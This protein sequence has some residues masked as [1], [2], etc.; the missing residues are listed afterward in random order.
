[1]LFDERVDEIWT[2]LDDSVKQ[3]LRD[4]TYELLFSSDQGKN[5][6]KVLVKAIVN[7][8]IANGSNVDTVA[9]ALRRR[10]G[11]FCSADDVIIFK[12]QE[13][14]K[15]A[16]EVGA[17]SD[18]GRKLLNDSLKLFSQVAGALSFENLHSAAEQ[19][20]NLQFYA[21]AISLA[22]LVAHE[23]DRGLR[24]LAWVNDFKPPDD[25]RIP[26]Y[27]FR[28]E[29]YDLIHEILMTVD[30]VTSS[31]PE[32]IDG[33][34][35]L[36]ATKRNEAH[37]VVNDS[38]DELFQ[39]DLYEWYLQQGWIDM[40][41]SVDSTF[42]LQF[43]TKTASTSVERADLL[44]R[45]HALR[46]Q[47][48]EAASVQLELAKSEFPIPLAKRIEYLGRA[49][50]NASA[51]SP[52]IGRQA[53]QVLLYEVSELL[54]VANIQD[55]ILSRLRVDARCSD[56]QRPQLVKRLDGQIINLTEVS[57]M[58]ILSDI[59]LTNPSCIIPT[60]TQP[61]TSTS[62]SP[63]TN[64]LTTA[65]KPTSTPPGNSSSKQLIPEPSPPPRKP[66]NPTKQSSS[67]SATW[68]TASTSPKPPSPPK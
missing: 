58:Y 44:W 4:L 48:Y 64:A 25:S 28:K 62:A 20:S 13:Q 7:R 31:E 52:G 49:K 1:M 3:Q 15:K 39:F 27:N 67:P 47:F 11:S 59:R 5:L 65:T 40:L 66:K 61:A 46:D 45:Y 38:K 26:L 10:C 17:N 43:L 42:I 23:S 30:A 32:M 9:E 53:R 29:C 34:L 22:L 35:T 14:L 55:E 56:E 21:G 2:S 19:F 24:A 54:D 60:P 6:A 37:T 33:R 50:A 18:M 41:L 36:A 57:C 68:R 51:Q 8:N 16:S 63:S 12:A